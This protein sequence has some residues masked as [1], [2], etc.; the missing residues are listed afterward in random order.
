MMLDITERLRKWTI[1][2]GRF[3]MIPLQ[4]EA[5]DEIERLRE[6]LLEIANRAANM[7]DPDAADWMPSIYKLACEAV[8]E[9][10]WSLL[11]A[12]GY[13]RETLSVSFNSNRST[14]DL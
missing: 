11:E 14:P 7:M 3:N 12:A 13:T 5:A 6:V 2:F 4:R 10:P 1:L 8:G 9:N